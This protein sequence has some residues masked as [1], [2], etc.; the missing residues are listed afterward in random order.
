MIKLTD[1]LNL[2][3][4][5]FFNVFKELIITH[6]QTNSTYSSPKVSGITCMKNDRNEDQ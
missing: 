3:P 1:T 6:T 2:K 5:V 4:R